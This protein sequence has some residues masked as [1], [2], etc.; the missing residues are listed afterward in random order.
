MATHV[1]TSD[2][3]QPDIKLERKLR[4]EEQRLC[5]PVDLAVSRSATVSMNHPPLN[6]LDS[7]LVPELKR[8]VREVADD[9]S[10]RVTVVESSV[11]DF[12]AA[13]VDAGFASDPEGFVALGQHD[14]GYGGLTP[15][16][17]LVAS[18]RD[19]PQVTIAKLRG[20]LR[21]GGNELALS[22]PAVRR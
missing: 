1:A 16:Q 14:R 4:Y 21:G 11:P 22:G 15:M 8:F 9:T 20:Y 3:H 13:H 2:A 18:I 6:L 10:V 17:H 7:T 19:L 12:F 5:S